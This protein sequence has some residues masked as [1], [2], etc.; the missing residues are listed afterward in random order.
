MMKFIYGILLGLGLGILCGILVALK[1][2][3]PPPQDNQFQ[4]II[5]TQNSR[6]EGLNHR[7]DELEDANRDA[8]DLVQEAQDTVK[9]I[10]DE[11]KNLRAQ[12]SDLQQKLEKATE[13]LAELEKS[14]ERKIA[15]LMREFERLERDARARPRQQPKR[16]SSASAYFAKLLLDR[17]QKILRVLK[18][19]QG[20]S[21]E[22]I[23]ELGLDEETAAMLNELL[24]DEGDRAA[25]AIAV[26]LQNNMANPPGNLSEMNV[27]Q[28]LKTLLPE[29]AGEF[30]QI[31][32]LPLKDRIALIAGKKNHLDYLSRDSKTMKLAYA[33]YTVRQN[34]YKNAAG[35]LSPAKM[36][37]FKEKYLPANDFRFEGCASLAFGS[38]DWEKER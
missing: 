9:G 38:I 26:F 34:T 7:I 22:A 33:L 31:K 15:E 36:A 32:E 3:K 30:E 11:R 35:H 20:L 4:A 19:G 13:K 29:L 24:K 10:L 27:Q 5:D 21:A 14:R 8:E 18:I 12:L 1:E 2:G 37:L 6:I 17:A 25:D 16:T 28:L 23:A